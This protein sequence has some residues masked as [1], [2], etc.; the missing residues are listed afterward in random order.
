MA[1]RKH[2]VTLTMTLAGGEI[3]EN[4]ST[5][6]VTDAAALAWSRPA[7]SRLSS[8]QLRDLMNGKK[9]WVGGRA[10]HD[11]LTL[12]VSG[13]PADLEIGLQLAYL[14][15]T[16]PVIEPAAFAQ[17]K[18]RQAQ[19]IAARKL[20]P[21]G[22]LNEVIA[23]AFYPK[24]MLRTKPLELEQLQKIELGTAQAWLG[25]IMA[26]API[27]VSI[28]G[29]LDRATALALVER[30]LG[31]LPSRD[32]ISEKTLR[33]LRSLTRPAGPISVERKI[34]VRT[35][36]ALVMDG[37]F[38]ADIQNIRDVRLL[39][40]AARVLSTRMNAI[41]R[42]E[43]QLVYSIRASSQPSSEY[44]GFGTFVAR[45]PTDPA[46]TSALAT[47]LNEL[48]T[49]FAKDGPTDD[50]MAVAKR[51]IANLLDQQMK[52]PEFWLS[53]LSTLDY[54]GR[55]LDDIVSAPSAYQQFTAQDVREA[56]AR[57]YKPESRFHFV[58]SPGLLSP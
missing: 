6:G 51:Q 16:D 10:E 39:T 28:V 13:N 21:S 27:E 3:Q 29:D 40:V 37:F 15:L 31:A 24:D 57:Y 17:W 34:A 23:N 32:R 1:E 44:P 36:Q 20:Q 53:W 8:I 46:K 30:Y 19:S 56:F 9:V 2:E 26:E 41:I 35:P 33:H 52:E 54:R 55:S 47:V 12:T 58:I 42:E 5:R 22:V 11:S 43:K 18:E 38:G 25:K 7:T 49:A 45:A 50:E 14:L 48:Y 4:A